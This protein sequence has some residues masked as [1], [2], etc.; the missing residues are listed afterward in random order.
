MS[1]RAF[2]ASVYVLNGRDVLLVKHK[3]LGIWL[4]VGGEVEDNETPTEAAK[5]EV[6]EEIG[7]HVTFVGIRQR[8]GVDGE[9]VGFLG[10]EEHA[11]GSKGLH[12]CFSFVAR[13]S[14]RIVVSDGSFTE[15]RWHPVANMFLDETTESVHQY[16]NKIHHL[17]HTGAIS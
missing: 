3:R 12:M 5:R 15:H 13:A 11:C 17:M 1:R 14:S 10:Y 8:V 7:Q 6:L 2:A 9:P 16:V 4:P